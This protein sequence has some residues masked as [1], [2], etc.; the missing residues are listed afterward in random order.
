MALLQIVWGST[1][2]HQGNNKIRVDM[3]LIIDGEPAMSHA[4]AVCHRAGR[5]AVIALRCHLGD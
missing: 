3:P 2:Q 1:E 5:L 4:W